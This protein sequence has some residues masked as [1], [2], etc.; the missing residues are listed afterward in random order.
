MI[1]REKVQNRVVTRDDQ[2]VGT[3]MV[4]LHLTDFPMSMEYSGLPSELV[5]WNCMCIMSIMPMKKVHYHLRSTALIYVSQFSKL[6][7]VAGNVTC[8]TRSSEVGSL[9]PP[10]PPL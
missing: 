7:M 2:R 6:L 4:Q 1:C 5:L 3:I 9:S 8:N 10:P